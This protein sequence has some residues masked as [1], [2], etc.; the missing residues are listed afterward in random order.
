MARIDNRAGRMKVGFVPELNGEMIVGSD[1]PPLYDVL[2][3]VNRQNWK[4]KGWP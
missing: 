1:W 4:E 2:N 3:E